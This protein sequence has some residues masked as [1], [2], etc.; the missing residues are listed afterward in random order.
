MADVKAFDFLD[1]KLVHTYK[2]QEI[3][4]FDNVQAVQY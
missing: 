3:D 4:K 1:N 2:Y